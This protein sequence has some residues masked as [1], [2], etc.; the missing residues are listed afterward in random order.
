MPTVLLHYIYSPHKSFEVTMH[1]LDLSIRPGTGTPAELSL[2]QSPRDKMDKAPHPPRLQGARHHVSCYFHIFGVTRARTRRN[3]ARLSFHSFKFS[4][5]VILIDTFRAMLFRILSK[6]GQIIFDDPGCQLVSFPQK[7]Y[8]HFCLRC[9][10]EPV[11]LSTKS[12]T[13]H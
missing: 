1:M 12:T 5:C 13:K 4:Q 8:I 7:K 9:L 2:F 6:N 10:M 3:A 11:L